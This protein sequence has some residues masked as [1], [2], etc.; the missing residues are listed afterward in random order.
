LAWNNS[1]NLDHSTRTETPKQR[2]IKTQNEFDE[3]PLDY[4]SVLMNPQTRLL[5]SG[6]VSAT[7]TSLVPLGESVV[8]DV[9]IVGII[10]KSVR[11]VVTGNETVW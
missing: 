9:G 5:T 3:N 11:W 6:L 10:W 4:R 1:D 8:T 2:G 7:V